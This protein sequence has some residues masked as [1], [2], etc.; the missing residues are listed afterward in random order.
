MRKKKIDGVIHAFKLEIRRGICV[1]NREWETLFIFYDSE[2]RVI[3]FEWE[4][5]IDIKFYL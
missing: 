1:K 5:V 4:R 2:I 3:I